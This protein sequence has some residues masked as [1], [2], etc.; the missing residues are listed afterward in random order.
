MW[1]RPTDTDLPA[2]HWLASGAAACGR[3]L[4]TLLVVSVAAFLISK[5]VPGDPAVITLR[6]QNVTPTP[7]LVAALHRAWGLDL[8]L[9]VQYLNW[10]GRYV[11]GD[12]GV[13]FR[14]G[15]PILREFA[16]RLPLS[17]GLGVGSLLIAALA[18]VPLGFAAA[19]RPAGIV[20]KLSRAIAIAVQAIPA[21]WLGLVL[22][23]ILGVKLHW[24]TP[25]ATDLPNLLLPLL[26]L[27]LYSVG[28]LSRV[29]RRKL[30][31]V[32][33]E[34][35]FRTALAKGLGRGRALWRHG[36]PHGFYTLLAALR[37]QAVWAISGT[38]TIEVLFGLPGISQFLVQSIAYQDYFVLQ[39]YVMVAAIWMAIMN[40]AI[41][42]ALSRL[43]ARL[44]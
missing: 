21:F 26:L 9:P 7:D 3:L 39:A 5:A 6:G 8:P 36:H 44:A 40:A 22:V 15:E 28:T 32:E 4:A 31:E 38:A 30:V 42:L 19:L 33:G 10:L 16:V 18:S 37:A 1:S 23:W 34:P 12:W 17:V 43:D 41:L 14:T 13:S 25:F 24:I 11:M 20:D 27:S 35:F 29:Y 2:Q